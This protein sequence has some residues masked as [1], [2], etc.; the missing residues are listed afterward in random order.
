V[1]GSAFANDQP[2][3]LTLKAETV[4]T[5]HGEATLH[6]VSGRDSVVLFR[7]ALPHRWLPHQIPYRAHA[8]ALARVG[9]TSLVI[10]SSVGVLDPAVPLHQPL[11]VDDLLM[12]EN[13]LPDGTACTMFASPTS[14]HG[15]LVLDEGLCS[16]ALA[17]Q[18]ERI[19]NRLTSPIAGHVVFAY[20]QGP[21][22]K[23]AAENRMWRSL[24]AQVNSM[25]VGPELVLSNELG[26]A[27]TALVIGHKYS[28]PG[29]VA[30]ETIG[31]SLETGR[32][33]FDRLLAALV[34]ELTPV[35]FGNHV[36]RF[37]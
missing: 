26:I 31:A 8:A 16:R 18:I 23:T 37:P 17:Q 24:G 2:S 15:H 30:D 35:A 12:P 1:L 28:I 13:R 7:H 19:A 33:T 20:A 9:V 4:P 3:G 14:D 5:P 29:H 22:T 10:T 36:H 32:R 21:R 11:L 25:T 6:R 34:H 27:A